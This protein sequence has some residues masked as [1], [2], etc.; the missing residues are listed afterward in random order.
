MIDVNSKVLDNITS[1]FLIPAKPEI[2]TSLQELMRQAEP[3][4]V[5][6]AALI[7]KDVATSAAILK[8]INSPFYGL[9]RTVSDIKQAVMFLGLNGIQSLVTA[10]Q[11]K[12]S[13]KQENSCIS[14]ERFWDSA[15][16]IANISAFVAQKFKHRVSVE[17][18]YTAGLFHDCGI[19]AMAANYSDYKRVL[20]EANKNYEIGQIQ[21][22]E[23]RYKTNH[24]VIGYFLAT[25]WHL[26][27][28]I[29]E[30]VLRHHELDFLDHCTDEE[31]RISYAALKLADNII[32]TNKR[33]I[34]TPDWPHVKNSVL[35]TLEMDND[36]YQDLKDDIDEM[37]MAEVV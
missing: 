8:T 14:L 25:S 12:Q 37:G 17:T 4:L 29:C 6:I 33:F 35:E 7:S 3:E 26:P 20:V 13:F 27:K 9:A 23:A 32:N 24:A 22:E 19:P 1:G 36:E 16:E 10:V 21:I 2:L 18:I 5:D 30:L 15:T 28:P 31:S 34:A 11:L